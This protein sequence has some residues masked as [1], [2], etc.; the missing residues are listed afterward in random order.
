MLCRKVK[1]CVLPSSIIVIGRA[2]E[3][4]AFI[5]RPA[6]AATFFVIVVSVIVVV[7]VVIVVI[8]TDSSRK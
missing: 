5:A 6:F 1:D 7:F 3:Q 2:A 4:R 8:K